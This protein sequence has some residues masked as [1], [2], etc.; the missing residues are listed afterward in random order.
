MKN[1][2]LLPFLFFGL[3]TANA[4]NYYV[5]ANGNDSNSGTS[6]SSPWKTIAKVNSI[7]LR[8]GDNVL[9]NRGDVFY[10]GITVNQSGTSSAPITYGAYGSGAKPVIT[11][12]TSVTSW[13][14]LGGNIWESSSAVSTLPY[15]N[16]VTVNGVNTAMGRWPN[17]TDPNKG[18]MTINSVSATT[19]LTSSQLSGSPNWTGAGIVI[20]KERWGIERGTVTS[21]SGTTISYKD[22]NVYTAKVGFGFFI[23]NDPRTLDVNNEWYYNPSTKK[24]RIYSTSTPGNVKIATVENLIY[25][26][27]KNYIVIKDMAFT[28][29]NSEALNCFN[30][31]NYLT[32]QNCD[33]SYSGKTGIWTEINYVSILNNTVSNVNFNGIQAIQSNA[34]IQYNN[35]KNIDMQEGMGQTQSSAGITT[36]GDNAI[37]QLNVIDSC[38]Y[39]GISFSGKYTLVKN[40]FIRN[41]C[42]IKDDGGGVY[43]GS[44]DRAKGSIIDGNIVL[45]AVGAVAGA[46]G[47]SSD[48]S[49]IFIDAYGTGITITNNTVANCKNAGIKL[50]GT[51]NI[52]IRNNTTYNNG[53]S[54]WTKGGLELMTRP[55]YPI[56]DISLYG[57]T[58]FAR[59][60]EQYTYFGSSSPSA[61]DDLK[62]FGK[63]D[64]NYFAKPI[65]P[66]SAIIINSTNYSLQGWQSYSGQGAHSK[67][68]PKNISNINDL[69]FEYNATSSSKTISLDASYIDVRNNSYNGSITLAPYTSAVLIRN[70]ALKNQPPIAIAGADQTITLPSNTVSLNGSGT[71]SDGSIVGYNWSKLS[72]P[73]GESITNPSS[74]STT[75]NNLPEGTYQFVLKVTDNAGAPGFDTLQVTVKG[76]IAYTAPSVNAGSDQTISLPTNSVTL[77]GSGSSEG[78]TIS[79]YNWTKTS[80][81]SAGSITNPNASSTSVTGLAEGVYTFQLK[82]TDG[83]GTSNTD[84]VQVSVVAS[85]SLLPAVNP[86]NTVNGIDYKYYEGSSF[87][88]V[89]DFSKLTPVKTGTVSNFDISVANRAELYAVEF[90]GYI[91]V[92]TDGEYTFYTNS[93]DGS[94]LYIDGQLIVSNDG[95]H[96]AQER[97]GTIGL[98][99]GKHAISVG[100]TQQY[101]GAVLSVSYS[102]PGITKRV[103]PN[104]ALYRA[105]PLLPA[106]NP[107]NTVNGIDYKY[108]E[109]SSFSVVPDFSKLTPVKTGTVSSFDISVANRAE[110]YAIEF[111][112][113]IDVPTDGEYTFYT[114][115]DDG[116]MLY[117]DGQLMVSNDG[118]HGAQERSGAIGLKAGKHVISVGYTQQYLSAVLSVS[119]SGPGIT[120]RVVPNSGLYRANPLL[121]AVN[122]GNTVN[123]IDYKYY[124]GSSF[125]VVPDFSKLTPVKTGTVSNFDI[126]VANRAELYTMEFKGY[127]DVPTDGEYTFYTN[128]DDGSKL[129]IDGQ[130]I[131][132]NDGLHGAQERSGAIGLKAGKHAISVGYAQQ[133]LSA[134]LS[135]SYSGPGITKRVVPNSAL[136]RT[137]VQSRLSSGTAT[138]IYSSSNLN[139]ITKADTLLLSQLKTGIAAY[140]NPFVSSIVVSIT[141]GAGAYHLLLSDVLGRIIW[142]R[143]G[144]K[145]AG[146]HQ[147]TINTSTLEKGIYFLKVVQNSNSSTI[148]L[149]K[150]E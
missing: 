13:T 34:S 125:S 69:R 66:G 137:S 140:P 21:Q 86:G 63:A 107:G 2:L 44:R 148:K 88:V 47:T 126:S 77:S 67:E 80:G 129:Y 119:Y 27:A 53:G 130:L 91:D 108:Y 76:S 38:G 114:N 45:N 118:L 134:V 111:N 94:M 24:I 51:N 60:S 49:G 68:A 57:N 30:Y 128:S 145:D 16:M 48:A 141:G 99:A 138:T 64:S 143:A 93:D 70:G 109:G 15:T 79:S 150:T 98:K 41:S 136:Y 131:V 7:T 142:I 36:T 33:V 1:L 10:G 123:G 102:G 82:V 37:I 25:L 50:H 43:M 28:G 65:D 23:Q 106:V 97:S 87:S 56:R 101:Q 72:G 110:L 20:R 6:P 117:I 74:A 144:T 71:D 132:S 146:A 90:K 19:S 100:Y 31:G 22:G 96:G 116:S 35:V 52:I 121:P 149:I 18:Y 46:P 127:I 89:P 9:F 81:P 104:S 3:A 29:S 59:T 8:P 84:A 103:V 14:N 40:N 85:G 17:S 62:L 39:N 124:E 11:G 55:D 61:P 5:A 83:R 42:I 92:P 78:G 122:P 147:Q 120:K 32:I 115:S 139:D 54:D 105:N 95:L 4:T 112:G 26:S 113:Y 12:F 135:V 75:V 133:Y 73:S 58:F